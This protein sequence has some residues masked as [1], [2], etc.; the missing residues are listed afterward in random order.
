[1]FY[2]TV[3]KRSNI[4]GIGALCLMVLV[5]CKQSRE[6]QIAA[7]PQTFSHKARSN[8]AARRAANLQNQITD[9]GKSAGNPAILGCQTRDYANS[10]VTRAVQSR[11]RI[12]QLQSL[13]SGLEHC[14]SAFIGRSCRIEFT[15]TTIGTSHQCNQLIPADMVLLATY[16]T[17]GVS[18]GDNAGEIPSDTDFQTAISSQVDGYVATPAGRFWRI[19]AFDQVATLICRECLPKDPKSRFA[20]QIFN[21]GSSYRFVDIIATMRKNGLSS[22]G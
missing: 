11:L 16:H 7:D 13:Q 3:R 21:V 8:A 19:D 12:L 14:G 2:L 22:G 18:H 4:I 17:H 9:G 6:E 15:E 10:A 5:A 20:A 1:M